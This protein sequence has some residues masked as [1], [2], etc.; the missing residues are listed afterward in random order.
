MRGHQIL[1]RR[2]C[3]NLIFIRIK[4]TGALKI[5]PAFKEIAVFEVEGSSGPSKLLPNPN[6]NLFSQNT[7]APLFCYASTLSRNRHVGGPVNLS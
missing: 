7:T 1:L 3:K 2:C 4:W 5:Q 6:F